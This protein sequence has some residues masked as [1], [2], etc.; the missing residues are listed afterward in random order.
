MADHNHGDMEIET[1]EKTFDGFVKA[2]TWSVVVIFAILILM[3][4]FIS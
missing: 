1:Q 3:A 4:M 2:T